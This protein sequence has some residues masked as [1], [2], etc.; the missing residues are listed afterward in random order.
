MTTFAAVLDDLDARI[1]AVL[2]ALAAGETPTLPPFTPP[3]GA[4]PIAAD[5]PRYHEVMQRLAECQERLA[6]AQDDAARG[7]ADTDRRREAATA[8]LQADA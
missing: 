5:L 7:L 4:V 1:D 2:R 3:R 8:Y 6:A